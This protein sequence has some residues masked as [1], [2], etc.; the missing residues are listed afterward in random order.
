[1]KLW[2]IGMLLVALLAA[3]KTPTTGIQG[4]PDPPLAPE[5]DL[6][7]GKI[8]PNYANAVIATFPELK[9]KEGETK[10]SCVPTT[11]PDGKLDRDG[12]Y[13]CWVYNRLNR[14]ERYIRGVDHALKH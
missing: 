6:K 10:A 9:V 14:L 5:F 1:M 13:R 8:N 4:I 2:M 3:C 7:T 11:L 12:V